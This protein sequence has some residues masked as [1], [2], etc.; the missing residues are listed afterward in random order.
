[1]GLTMKSNNE[2]EKLF[3]KFAILP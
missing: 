3:N 1:M 2:L